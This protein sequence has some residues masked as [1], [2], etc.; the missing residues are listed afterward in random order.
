MTIHDLLKAYSSAKLAHQ[1]RGHASER[2]LKRLLD[3]ILE[4]QVE[5]LTVQALDQL[6]GKMTAAAPVHGER[7]L[8]YV[9]PMLSWAE[10][11]GHI[12]ANP[13]SGFR[14]PKLRPARDRILSLEEVRG[15]YGVASGLPY[16]FGPAFQLLVLIPAT[17]ETVGGLRV[18]DLTTTSDG[19][20]AWRAEPQALASRLS[21][22]AARAVRAAMAHRLKGSDL[23]FST[24]GRSPISGWSRAKARLDG[25]M[26]ALGLLSEPWRLNDLRPSF[27]SIARE[28]LLVDPWAIER[29]LGR[30]NKFATPLLREWS[31]SP[32]LRLE[33][34]Q[35][36]DRWAT[37]VT[38]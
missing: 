35:A 10:A 33:A 25:E 16:P 29:C 5:A 26:A 15:I 19:G 3:P 2:S 7:A 18:A 23:V 21:G 1:R 17:R 6:V 20:L 22:P 14:G 24:T 11:Q 38:S 30:V 27:A 13:L 4:Q 34:D 32:E 28:E 8:G 36:L 12:P 37:L 9:G 31:E